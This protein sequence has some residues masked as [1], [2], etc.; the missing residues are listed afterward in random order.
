MRDPNTHSLQFSHELKTSGQNE[1]EEPNDQTFLCT[2]F[3]GMLEK[4]RTLKQEPIC[5]PS[6]NL[7]QG[8]GH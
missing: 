4:V 3:N 8:L 5:L 7:L 1:M 2:K 6:P